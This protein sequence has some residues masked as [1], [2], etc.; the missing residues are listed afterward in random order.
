MKIK[1]LAVL[2]VAACLTCFSF[3]QKKNSSSLIG[4]WESESMQDSPLIILKINSDSTFL[5]QTDLAADY[6]FKI[7]GNKMIRTLITK[8]SAQKAVD[9]SF[10]KL[11]RNSLTITF[12]Q[13]GKDKIISMVRIKGTR[14]GGR[15]ITGSYKSKYPDGKTAFSILTKDRK[16]HFRLPLQTVKGIYSIYND[17]VFFKYSNKPGDIEKRMFF[18]KGNRLMLRDTRTG[19]EEF[20]RKVDYFPEQ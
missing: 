3:A 18:I 15:S 14:Q 16:W 11:K 13:N 6:S 8:D 12:P 7:T 19:K 1:I 20:F 4:N 9:T 5:M 2:F 17:N 10:I